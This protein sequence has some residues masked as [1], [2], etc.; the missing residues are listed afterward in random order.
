M[1]GEK[2]PVDNPEPA[3]EDVLAPRPADDRELIP[4]DEAEGHEETEARDE[5]ESPEEV[6]EGLP[7][8][9]PEAPKAPPDPIRRLVRVA[10]A[11]VLVLVALV[12]LVTFGMLR[13][14]NEV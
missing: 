1:S 2:E 6:D 11:L 10:W 14:S 9:E 5:A 13:I 7:A 12:V 4:D 8:P 3:A